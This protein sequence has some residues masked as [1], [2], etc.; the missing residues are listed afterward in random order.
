METVELAG[1]ILI[2]DDDPDLC[3]LLIE[4]LALEGITAHAVASTAEGCLALEQES[5]ALILVDSFAPVFS[6]AAMDRLQPL[7]SNAAGTPMVLFT[8]HDD[9]DQVDLTKYGLAGRLLKPFEADD[10]LALVRQ[11]VAPSM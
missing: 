11:Y 8:A 9:A 2:V 4:L 5:F 7:R 1:R 10:L 3:A 6:E